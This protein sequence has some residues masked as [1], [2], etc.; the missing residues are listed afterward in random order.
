MA[1][2]AARGLSIMP[3][4]KRV[5]TI[6]FRPRRTFQA[7]KTAPMASSQ[8]ST[9]G[10]LPSVDTVVARSTSW[11]ATVCSTLPTVA[12]SKTVRVWVWAFMADSC[13]RGGMMVI[14]RIAP[15][16]TIAPRQP[17]RMTGVTRPEPDPP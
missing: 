10:P 14:L 5:Q 6:D 2:A 3:R 16:R 11:P 13:V 12:F 8:R 15:G 4:P 9:C 1:R 17:S 7:R